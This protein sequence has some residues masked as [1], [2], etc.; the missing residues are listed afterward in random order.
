MA[1]EVLE[2]MMVIPV[3]RTKPGSSTLT[4]PSPIKG[5]GKEPPTRFNEEPLN[6]R[7]VHLL[8]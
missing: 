3:S 5:E 4:L 1:S 8:L 7:L 6:S 2:T